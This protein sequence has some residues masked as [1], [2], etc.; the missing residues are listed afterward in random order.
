M[1]EKKI[2]SSAGTSVHR[3]EL[4]DGQLPDMA[5]G[6]NG[7]AQQTWLRPTHIDVEFDP[8][9]VVETRIYG[10]QIKQDGSLSEREL[11]HRWRRS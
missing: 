1:S 7:V 8:K 4:A 2:R 11:D 5:C 9:G 10:P 3:I 6:V